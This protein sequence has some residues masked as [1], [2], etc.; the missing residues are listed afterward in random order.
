MG[1]IRDPVLLCLFISVGPRTERLGLWGAAALVAMEQGRGPGAGIAAAALAPGSHRGGVWLGAHVWFE[2]S[3]TGLGLPRDLAA[4]S[5]DKHWKVGRASQAHKEPSVVS[6]GDE[7][8][9][10]PEVWV[11]RGVWETSHGAPRPGSAGALVPK[12]HGSVA[13]DPGLN[14]GSV[15][16]YAGS[17]L[18]KPQFP[19]LSNRAAVEA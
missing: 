14:P 11:R 17:H 13:M 6:G 8:A 12:R 5:R 10:C 9:I 2:I 7:G 18:F 19:C 1:S 3:A 16:F 15:P 4:R